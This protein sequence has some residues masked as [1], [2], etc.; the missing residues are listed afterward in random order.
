[1]TDPC[2]EA[3]QTALLAGSQ[4]VSTAARDHVVGITGGGGWTAAAPT[5]LLLREIDES[6]ERAAGR[7]THR[8][9]LIGVYVRRVIFGR[10]G[11]LGVRLRGRPVAVLRLRPRHL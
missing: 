8:G 6:G 3:A 7:R 9:R 4:C 1:M 11:A 2:V 10:Y 5:S